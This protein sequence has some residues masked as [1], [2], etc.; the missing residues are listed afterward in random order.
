MLKLI[1]Q[2]RG[3]G[4]TAVLL[5]DEELAIGTGAVVCQAAR[6]LIE[7]GHDPGERLEA[8]RGGTMCLSGTIG[9]FARLTVNEGAGNGMPQCAMDP[10][11]F[12]H[13]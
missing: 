10:T 5:H 1:L 13:S 12:G 4:Q 3:S 11:A 6:R 2:P 7:R 8:W 9:G